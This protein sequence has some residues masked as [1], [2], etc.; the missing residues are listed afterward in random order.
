MCQSPFIPDGS[1]HD[2]LGDLGVQHRS[3]HGRPPVC[4]VLDLDEVAAYWLAAG[5][6][7]HIDRAS[8]LRLL[9]PRHRRA[10]SSLGRIADPVFFIRERVHFA[11]AVL[12][13]ECSSPYPLN[14]SPMLTG[15]L[16]RGA[17]ARYPATAGMPQRTGALREKLA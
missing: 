8:Q 1:W 4:I 12:A 9:L 6:E 14:L 7:Q 2:R 11:A 5:D 17:A 15:G 13:N 16:S 3:R 10:G